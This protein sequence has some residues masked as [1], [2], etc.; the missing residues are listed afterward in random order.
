M[1]DG[2][3]IEAIKVDL[4]K[5]EDHLRLED[6]MLRD[7]KFAATAMLNFETHILEEAHFSHHL[8]IISAHFR[9][10]QLQVLALVRGLGDLL[11][12]RVTPDLIS[13][14]ELKQGFEALKLT[15]SLQGLE[16]LLD[17]AG[18]LYNLPASHFYSKQ[19]FTFF[20]AIGVPLGDPTREMKLFHYLPFPTRLNNSGLLSH[21]VAL[22]EVEFL[23]VSEL[24]KTYYELS[25][26]DLQ[27]CN[28]MNER[29]ICPPTGVQ[30]GGEESCLVNL[31]V[32]NSAGIIRNCEHKLARRNYVL[33]KDV[34][35][36]QVYLHS[37]E[38]IKLECSFSSN[39]ISKSFQGIM[40]ITLPFG[41]SVTIANYIF[42]SKR[43]VFGKSIQLKISDLPYTDELGEE[44]LER[45]HQLENE[46]NRTLGHDEREL[47]GYTFSVDL[48]AL[49]DHALG[50]G[51]MATIVLLII[52][53]IL[54]GCACWY[55]LARKKL[56]RKLAN[57]RAQGNVNV[58][59]NAG[60]R[61]NSHENIPLNNLNNQTQ[62]QNP[63]PTAPRRPLGAQAYPNLSNEP[64]SYYH[65]NTPRNSNQQ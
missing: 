52:F 31:Y 30:L 45:I 34:H 17:E 44:F 41:C 46:V 26:G 14:G 24:T 35:T 54:I 16:P 36:F 3:D 42:S 39:S 47:E 53:A 37:K 48:N 1:N 15:A 27:L 63:P 9:T 58:N 21:V 2:D 61:Q 55:K 57:L 40:A 5:V 59:I 10:I 65:G 18:G 38:M 22:P 23:G 6:N 51:A 32:G 64:D 62:N 7:L 28:K 29:Y 56:K 60:D 25:A 8:S 12:H 50:A 11:H 33:Q 13:F 20:I 19:N 4:G 43:P 49:K